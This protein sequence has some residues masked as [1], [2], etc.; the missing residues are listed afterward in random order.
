M[1]MHNSTV[2]Y[3]LLIEPQNKFAQNRTF[4]K[5]IDIVYELTFIQILMTANSEKRTQYKKIY[6]KLFLRWQP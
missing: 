4:D 6:C 3:S 2:V 1:S 5:K